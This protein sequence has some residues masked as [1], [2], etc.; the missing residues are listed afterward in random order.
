MQLGHR[1]WIIPA[2]CHRINGRI[3]YKQASLASA[4]TNRPPVT[5]DQGV[6]TAGPRPD[7]VRFNRD[8]QV[9]AV[10]VPGKTLGL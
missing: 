5:I 3:E 6:L 9:S 4:R 7:Q 1:I 10:E 2:A 8:Q